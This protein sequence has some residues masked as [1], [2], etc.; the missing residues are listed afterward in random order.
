VRWTGC[1]G[2]SVSYSEALRSGTYVQIKQVDRV[3]RTD[4]VLG[5]LRVR[6]IK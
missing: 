3:D 1:A 6:G 4:Q 2:T 5:S